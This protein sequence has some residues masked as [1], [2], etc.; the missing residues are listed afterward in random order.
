VNHAGELAA[1]GTS[2]GFT[3]GP[4]FFAL[5]GRRLGSQ[6]VNRTRLL[7]AAPLLMLLHLAL[8]GSLLPAAT[9]ERW[10]WLGLSGLVGLVAGDACLFR[11]FV[12]I[13]PR[14]TMLIYSLNPLLAAL[15]ARLLFGERLGIWQMAA[16]A[17]TLAGVGW[18]VSERQPASATPAAAASPWPG[19]L[20]ALG[21]A[22]GQALGL[23]LARRGLEGGF[24]SLSAHVMR[25]CAA[26][27]G[28]WLLALAQRQ[29]LS[30]LRRVR[31]SPRGLGQVL[32]GTVF[33]PLA[34]VWLS[35]I[36]IARTE[37][38][39]ASTLMALPPVLLL[40]VGHLV[41]GE[42]VALRAVAGT[43]LAVAGAAALFLL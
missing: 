19:L 11:A 9:P 37:L 38:G 14:L 7:A 16:M 35:L 32:A 3:L 17:A 36:A 26:A 18:V 30:T 2:L 40:P 39:V 5:A 42:R 34:G 6:V 33:G 21:G 25:M 43:L 22:A 31:H 28:I 12:L 41:F 1:L 29:A 13:G 27:G 20:L 24:P 4:T 23:V 10:L 8:R 15:L